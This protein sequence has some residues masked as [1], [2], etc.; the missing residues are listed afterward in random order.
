MRSRAR[1]LGTF[2]QWPQDAPVSAQALVEAGFFYVGPTD[3]VQ[4]F[5]CGGV[6]TE[7]RRGDCPLRAHLTYFPSCE[8][9]N[10]ERVGI[11]EVLSSLQDVL[12]AVDGQI[13]SVLQ[14]VGREEPA[15]PNDPEYPDM[16]TEEMR[17]STFENW[18]QD[19]TVEPEHL[20]R[21]GFFYTGEGDLVKCFYCDGEMMNWT[22]GDDPWREHARWYPE[23]GFLLHSMGTE[24][25]S[26]IQESLST[27]PLTPRDSWD[28]AEQESSP[29]QGPLRDWELRAHPSEE[30]SL[31]VQ[32]V[33]QMGFD[34]TWV[35]NLVEN[36]FAQTGTFY[37]SES[38]LV[39]DLVHS[40]CGASSSPG[41][42]RDGS[43]LST[44]EQLRRLQEERMCKV[45]MDKDVSVVFVPCGHLV[46]CAECALNLRRCPICRAAIQ[47]SV[48]AFMS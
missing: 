42:S 3:E 9:L 5:C 2:R 48:R 17:L 18:P 33:L 20:A 12:D 28:E 40:G 45:C 1:R 22:S 34:P 19:S 15:L 8:Y 21:A 32:N 39:A 26:S 44:E 6:L 36:K 37:L 35:T 23:C 25:V 41:E 4:C 31:I 47:G 7:W 10:E 14:G 43:Q 11:Q 38:E 24:F 30:Q 46:A 29:S 13:L 16:E 27:S